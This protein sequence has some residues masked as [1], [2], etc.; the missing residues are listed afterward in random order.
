MTKYEFLINLPTHRKASILRYYNEYSKYF[1]HIDDEYS[2][3][4]F[5]EEFLNI[6]SLID[7]NS[8]MLTDEEWEVY[9]DLEEDY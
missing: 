6:I 3:D 4:D 8:C 9:E 1:D 5:D 2:D 7:R